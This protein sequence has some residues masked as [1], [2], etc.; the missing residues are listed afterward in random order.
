MEQSSSET[1]SVSF[2][3]EQDIPP[4]TTDDFLRWQAEIIEASRRFEGFLRTENFPP[5][6]NNNH[7]WYTVI[8][9]DTPDNLTK[10]L[11]SDVRH[12]YIRTR[13]DRFGFYRF[14]SYKTGFEEWLTKQHK[15][16]RWKQ[17]LSV[18]FGLYPTIMLQN[19]LFFYWPIMEHWSL[20]LKVL[21]NNLL[22][23]IILTWIVMPIVTKLFQFWLKPS[24]PSVNI[25]RIGVL[26]ILLGLGLMVSFFTAIT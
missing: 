7:K 13:Q 18:L 6:V 5:S 11:D 21:T 4:E 14:Y 20:P 8:H 15:F 25:D 2:I 9:F 23:C 17:A 19:I 10:W 3:I 24:K 22:G 16:P 26:L 1:S 12:Q